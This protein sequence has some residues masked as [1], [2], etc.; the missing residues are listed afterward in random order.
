MFKY[1]TS[2]YPTTPGGWQQCGFSS[3]PSFSNAVSIRGNHAYRTGVP[4]LRAIVQFQLDASTGR[5][6]LVAHFRLEARGSDETWLY[7]WYGL[8]RILGQ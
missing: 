6:R 4:P 5:L 1:K 2:L 3:V 8:R 7:P